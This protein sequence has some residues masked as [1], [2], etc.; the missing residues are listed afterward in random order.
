MTLRLD[1]TLP[2]ESLPAFWR[3][4]AL[5]GAPRPRS[6]AERWAWLDTAQGGLAK[7]G[8][9]LRELPQGSRRLCRMAPPPGFCLP[10]S[11]P[12]TAE[13]LPAGTPPPEAGGAALQ[14]FAHYV[15]RL[16]LRTAVAGGIAMQLRSGTV[17]AGS[18]ARPIA[19]LELEGPPGAV[20]DLIAALAADLPL[21]PS[22]SGLDA[23]ALSPQGGEEASSGGRRGPPDLGTAET[24]ADALALA[25]AH[26]T[27]VL[28]TYAPLA[29]PEN[30]PEAVHQLR[31]AARRLRSCLRLFRPALDGPALRA[32]DASLRDFA[33]ALGE[34]REWD[35][36]LSELGAEVSAALGPD[37]RWA[38]LLRAAEARR[39]TAYEALCGMLDGPAF[40]QMV[41]QAV[42]LAAL[43]DWSTKAE[44]EPPPLRML[45]A[46]LLTKR[47]RR[48]LKDGRGMETLSDEALHEVR[49]E[50]KRLR[51]AA[52]LFAPLWPGRPAR[53]F[54]KRVAALQQ[55]LG[56]AN[57][58]VTARALVASLGSGA[59]AWAIGLT[60]G[61]ALASSRGVRQ[62][63][64][65]A[66]RRFTKLEPFWSAS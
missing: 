17:T 5:A 21:L 39:R 61:W 42:R 19:L 65:P 25:I 30:G 7:A 45:A 23:M 56:L 53:R 44:A 57:D 33:R 43:R 34:A 10:G 26:L 51:Y 11:P 8:L 4:A 2:T 37:R 60:E 14:P 62:A 46:G 29:R 20:L 13:L 1:L 63:A 24:A 38:R 64:L 16:Q 35:V 52:E 22:T 66:W 6:K 48:L 47:R 54:L 59:P 3:H 28:L 15:G 40:R 31:V 58:T 18:A 50:A 49:L 27:D 9:A 36:F 55:A 12:A 32:L 41:W